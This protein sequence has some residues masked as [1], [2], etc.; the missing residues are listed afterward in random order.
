MDTISIAADIGSGAGFPGIP[1]KIV[2]PHLKL[3][4]ID[5]LNKRIDFLRHIAVALNLQNIVFVHARA[6]EAGQLS[7]YREAFDLVTARAVARMNVLNELC[8]PFAKVGGYFLAMKGADPQEEVIEAAF[9]ME[10]LKGE[11]Q[12]VHSLVLPEDEAKRHIIIIRKTD[13]TPRK[14]PRNPGTPAKNPLIEERF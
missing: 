5:S 4:I 7:K 3:T 13:K 14:F 1:L 10:V 12:G 9:S 2:Y 11:L 8:L 6:E